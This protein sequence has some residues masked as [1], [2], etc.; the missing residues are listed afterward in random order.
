MEFWILRVDEWKEVRG[1]RYVIV[2]YKIYNRSLSDAE[3]NSRRLRFRFRERREDEHIDCLD[4]I[5]ISY[6]PFQTRPV[7]ITD[8]EFTKRGKQESVPSL[9]SLPCL[10]IEEVPV[11]VER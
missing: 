1:E 3:I 7:E 2:E 11:V 8:Y 4:E 9:Q 10:V 6:D 5:V